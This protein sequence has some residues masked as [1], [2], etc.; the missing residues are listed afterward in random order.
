MPIY[1]Y[2]CRHC[3]KTFEEIVLSGRETVAC[4][5]CTS[6]DVER[7]LSIFSSPGGHSETGGVGGGCGGCTP[8]TCGCH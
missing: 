1:E 3:D 6:A 8:G 5:E 2:M 4:P 7:Q